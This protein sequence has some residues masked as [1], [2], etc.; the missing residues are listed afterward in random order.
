MSGHATVTEAMWDVQELF[1]LHSRDVTRYLRRRVSSPDTAADLVQDLFLKLLTADISSSITDRRSYLFRAA[2][3]LAI[4]HNKREGL[5]RFEDP[6]SLDAIVDDSPSA[7]RQL[8]SKQ[9]LMIVAEVLA[10]LSPVQ[11]KIFFLTKIDGLTFPA[12][13]QK[14]GLAPTT[15]HSHMVRILMRIQLRFKNL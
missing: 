10:G 6:S 11:R 12:I 7:E 13:G 2:N 3:N 14:L 5:V 8:L 4:N 1:R 9:E 15:V